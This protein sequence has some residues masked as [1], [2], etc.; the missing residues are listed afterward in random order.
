MFVNNQQIFFGP[1]NDI[2]NFSLDQDGLVCN[3]DYVKSSWVTI[4][5]GEVISSECKG[6]RYIT[7][8]RDTSY[9]H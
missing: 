8:F 5:N 1:N 9:V 7:Y 4:K 2:P 3:N 6:L